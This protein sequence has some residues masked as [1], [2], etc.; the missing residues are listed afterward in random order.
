MSPPPPSQFFFFFL[1]PGDIDGNDDVK[2]IMH[3]FMGIWLLLSVVR[4]RAFHA[5]KT[6]Q[7]VFFFSSSSTWFNFGSRA[8]Y[9][10]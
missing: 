2:K 7:L 3:I 6:T 4:A 9:A 5:R 10:E 8:T 1:F